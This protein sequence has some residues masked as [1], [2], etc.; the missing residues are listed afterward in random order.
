VNADPA[1]ANAVASDPTIELE[2]AEDVLVDRRR[3][4]KTIEF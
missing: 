4:V 2:G 1:C 3:C